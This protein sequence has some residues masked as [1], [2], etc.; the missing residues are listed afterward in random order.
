M[1]NLTE[2][3]ARIHADLPKPRYQIGDRVFGRKEKIPFVGSVI[4][5]VNEM[6]MI[7]TD[8]PIKF[9]DQDYNII[10]VKRNVLSRLV[11]M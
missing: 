5:E 10:T 1:S 9:A 3:Y 2:Y 4:R 8:L 7:H 11:E 6:V